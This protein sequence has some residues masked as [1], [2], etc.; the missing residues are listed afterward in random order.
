MMG[1]FWDR[2]TAGFRKAIRAPEMPPRRSPWVL[3][4]TL[5]PDPTLGCHFCGREKRES[6]QSSDRQGESDF[7]LVQARHNPRLKHIVCSE[8]VQWNR[9][10]S[11]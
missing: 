6:P 5:P 7:A 1:R 10:T 2:L 3:V 4:G 8:C 11:A 9:I